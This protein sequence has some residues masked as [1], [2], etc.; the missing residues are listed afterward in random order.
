[1]PSLSI[2]IGIDVA[3]AVGKRLPICV[4]EAGQ[5]LMPLDI[6]SRLAAAIPQGFSPFFEIA[7]LAQFCRPEGWPVHEH[8]KLLR[9]GAA[10]FFPTIQ[11]SD[12][13]EPC[14]CAG[15]IFAVTPGPRGGG[16]GL[17]LSVDQ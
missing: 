1:V 11:G 16:P 15:W 14:P 17:D 10:P 3:C 7:G 2:Y 6:P 5:P 8:S 13:L 4:V 9:V 12:A